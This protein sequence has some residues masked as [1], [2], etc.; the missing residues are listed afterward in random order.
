MLTTGRDETSPTWSPTGTRFACLT[1]VR[2]RTEVW[3]HSTL[4]GSSTPILKRGMDGV[5]AWST[6]QRTT[7]SPDG[8]KIAYGV[9][10][11]DRHA[12]WVSP[13][14]GGQP[15]PLDRD[16]FDQHGVTWSPDSNSIAYHRLRDGAWELVRAPLGGLVAHSTFYNNGAMVRPQEGDQM[17]RNNA[18]MRIFDPAE[19]LV[20]VSVAEPDGALLD[21]GLEAMVYVD[22]YP[23]LALPADGLLIVLGTQA[24]LAALSELASAV[25]VE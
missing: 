17:T 1:N 21:E 18:I 23:D 4:D 15:V 22:A 8:L 11:S 19:M 25:S 2:G 3:L 24:E 16:S 7:F 20:R 12:I 13:V 10:Q 5:P 14:T 6:L 9:I